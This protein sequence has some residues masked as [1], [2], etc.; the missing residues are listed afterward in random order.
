MSDVTA[1]VLSIG[2][3]Y[4]DR[5]LASVR[6]QTL[7][8]AETVVVRDVSPFH[9]ALNA[10]AAQVRTPFFLHVDADMI[11]DESCL[12]ALRPLM[13]DGVGMVQGRLRDPLC[14]R[15]AGIRLV[16][17]GCWA[18]T[19]YADSIAPESFFIRDL[20][21]NG[22]RF[23]EALR[24]E[25]AN[26]EASHSFGEHSPTYDLVYTLS[27]FRIN[28]A[29]YRLLGRADLLMLMTE[30]MRCSGHPAAVAALIG[31]THGV[32]CLVG[33]S[34]DLLRRHTRDAEHAFLELFLARP[35]TSEDCAAP[36][37]LTD[38]RSRVFRTGY[39]RGAELGRV[40]SAADLRAVVR[41][42]DRASPDIRLA[43][44][45]GLGHGFFHSMRAGDSLGTELAILDELFAGPVPFTD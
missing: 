24:Y 16:R 11:L 29:R 39:R 4:T 43:A 23:V 31:L 8:P 6:R 22:W 33:S 7:P 42:L 1:V 13:T 36:L 37:A 14:G 27:K 19:P 44:L 34:R 40:G 21:K 38:S 2:E 28:G 30:R 17:T 18:E 20:A 9:C 10:G 35:S 26:R 15:I 32:F 12:A 45:L 41:G 25:G 5:A 3:P